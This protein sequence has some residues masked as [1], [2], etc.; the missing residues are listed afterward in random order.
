MKQ[1]PKERWVLLTQRASLYTGW[2]K[3]NATT[4]IRN[5]IDILDWMPLIFTVLDRIILFQVIWHQV[6]QVWIRRFDSRAIFFKAVSFSKRATFPPTS[7]LEAAGIFSS[8]GVP[9]CWQKHNCPHFEKEDN[10]NETEAFITQLCGTIIGIVPQSCVMH[11]S[12][13]FILSS[14]LKWGQLCFLSTQLI[15]WD[16]VRWKIPAA[17]SLLAGG[18]VAHFENDTA[19]E[20]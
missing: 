6:H 11:S 19:S 12:V 7:R 20:N 15:Q 5:F 4:L 18:K 13:S 16:A 14:I 10:M 17:S 3:Q 2:P 9:L 8:D 1:S